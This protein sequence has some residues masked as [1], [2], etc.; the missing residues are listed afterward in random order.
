MSVLFD[1]D[2]DDFEGL[3]IYKELHD[4]END[5]FEDDVIENDFDYED[6]EEE[7]DDEEV[8]DRINDMDDEY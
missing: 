4:L 3:V 8:L 1:D 7:I 6:N 5:R 2:D